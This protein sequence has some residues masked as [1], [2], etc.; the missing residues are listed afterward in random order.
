MFPASDDEPSGWVSHARPQPAGRTRARSRELTAARGRGIKDVVIHYPHY[1]Y[2]EGVSMRSITR[3]VLPVLVTFAVLTLGIAHTPA[4]AQEKAAKAEPTQEELAAA[5][6]A[7][8]D[9]HEVIFELWHDA[10]PDKNTDL[11]KSLL[12]DADEKTAALDKAVLPGILRDKQAA[13]DEG[14]TNLNAALERLHEAADADDRQGMLDA[15]EAFH[16]AFERLVRTIRPVI[17]EL[18]AFHQELYGLYHYYAPEYDL[19]KIRSATAAMQEKLPALAKAKLPKRLAE[20]QKD[21]DES[22]KALDSRVNDLAGIVKTDDKK[23]I[24]QAVDKVHTAY[25][26]TESVFD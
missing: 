19:E 15:T 1:P 20:R 2:P 6:P 13:W 5:V 18:D 3:L 22:V 8:D 9:L 16:S 25:Q 10:F 17:P 7:L 24:L 21:F 12:P 14:K 26:R 23:K 11:I 4:W